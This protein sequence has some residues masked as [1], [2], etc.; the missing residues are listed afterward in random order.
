MK[1]YRPD[2]NSFITVEKEGKKKNL[3]KKEVFDQF[4]PSLLG[5]GDIK[6]PSIAIS[7]ICC[8][9]DLGGFTNFCKQIDPQLSVSS[10]LSG[11]LDWIFD[12]IRDKVVWE[13]FEEGISL[14]HALPFY[15]KFLGD[16]LL[17]LCDTCD[18]SPA[19]QHNVIANQFVYGH[20]KG[21]QIKEFW[22]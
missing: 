2:Q 5:L 22:P 4:N 9:Y 16:G 13:R 3:L 15:T 17:I 19:A 11:F 12:K 7:A 6:Q 1:I 14:Y 21:D 20:G 8:V 18:M 10:Y